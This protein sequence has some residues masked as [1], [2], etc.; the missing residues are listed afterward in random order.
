MAINTATAPALLN[1]QGH[2]L[3]DFC[4]PVSDQTGMQGWDQVQGGEPEL[5]HAGPGPNL[6]HAEVGGRW[7]RPG[8][9]AQ[10]GMWG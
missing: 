6:I 1:F 2:G 4:C 7:S 8:L 10:S 3:D 9:C 5:A